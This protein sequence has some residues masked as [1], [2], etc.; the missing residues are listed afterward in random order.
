M[1]E[2]RLPRL[3]DDNLL[4]ITRL[5]PVSLSIDLTLSPMSTANMV[6]SQDEAEIGV[7]QFVE[8]FTAQG[9]AG[10]FIVKSVE[11]DPDRR[12][13]NV[14]LNHGI[15]TLSNNLM[16]GEDEKTG[17]TADLLTALLDC[18]TRRLWTLGRV[19]VPDD[20]TLR[21]ECD[22]SNVLQSV[23]NLMEQLPTYALT[24]DQSGMPWVLNVASM[25]DDDACECRLTRNL[26]SLTI[27]I[28]K[29]DLCTRVFIRGIAKLEKEDS[30][31]P[32]VQPD[33]D[34]NLPPLE[35][36]VLPPQE[37]IVDVYSAT[38]EADTIG[39]WGAVDRVLEADQELPRD[40]LIR[41]GEIF[42]EERKNPEVTVTLDAYDLHQATGEPFDR[43]YLGRICRVCLPEYGA[44]IRH[45]VVGL[46]FTDAIN[47]PERVTVTLAA[48]RA[49]GIDT[50]TGIIVNT[51]MLNNQVGRL[52]VNKITANGWLE[53]MADWMN[54]HAK[55]IR[56]EADRI[57][58]IAKE[59][60]LQAD[61]IELNAEQIRIWG[62]VIDE[63]NGRVSRAEINIDA[64]NALIELK[65]SREEVEGLIDRISKAEITIDGANARIDLMATREEVDELGT[66]ISRAEIEIDGANAAIA[67]KANQMTVDDLEARMNSAEIEIDG[68]NA[69]ID[70]KASQTVVD[71]LGVRVSSAE[72]AIDG[73]NSEISLKAD[74]ILLQGYVKASELETEVLD[75]VNA[76]YIETLA[77]GF[78]GCGDIDADTVNCDD[79][80]T[81]TVD[82]DMVATETLWATGAHITSMTLGG[83]A[84]SWGSQSVVTSMNGVT[85]EYT[86]IWYMDSDG[87]EQYAR[88][89]TNVEIRYPNTTTLSYLTG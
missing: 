63:L 35:D 60:L 52:Q 51:A 88:V 36:F 13:Q 85:K 76:S 12:Q 43:F 10:V 67:L 65:A 32:D 49:D 48:K 46:T 8:L 79:V 47:E 84:V 41:Q 4:E 83:S 18:Q 57:E 74:T 33:E 66:R 3:L 62:E 64:A 71:N 55:Y 75:V 59:I 86:D 56:L 37:E 50:I 2:V 14:Q 31:V 80:N 20:T 5:H 15:D 9:S 77:A 28:D 78:I 40:E 82:C 38:L 81:G 72:I 11:Y 29:T 89:L 22:Y 45:R 19:D 26:E 23:V 7:G 87:A 69:R 73:L 34:G 1:T 58:L 68:A 17:T 54:L 39:I 21:W 27:N 25:S 24:F 61:K 30:G 42:L 53:L 70:L 6:V 16:E 44:V